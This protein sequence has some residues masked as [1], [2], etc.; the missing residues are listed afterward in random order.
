MRGLLSIDMAR[1]KERLVMLVAD[2]CV[3]HAKPIVQWNAHNFA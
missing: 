2:W 3:L 1:S